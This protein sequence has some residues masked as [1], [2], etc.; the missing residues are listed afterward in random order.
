MPFWV[1]I[2]AWDFGTV[3]KYFEILKGRYQNRICARL[4]ID[5]P[6]V[7]KEWLQE[8]NT[9]RNRCAHHTRIWNQVAANPLPTLPHAYFEALELDEQARSRL[10]GLIAIIW[11]LV[12][13]IGPNSDWLQQVADLIDTKPSP[14]G[15]HFAAMGFPGETGFPRDRF[16]I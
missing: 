5:N 16:G 13:S 15:C 11:Y 9:L 6:R 14:P 4:G 1:V 10:Y 3:S 2:E 8:L 7:L 12:K